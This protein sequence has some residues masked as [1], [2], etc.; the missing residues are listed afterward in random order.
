[1]PRPP[2]L[3][4]FFDLEIK[5]AELDRQAFKGVA[6]TREPDMLGDV[7]EPKG[8]QFK[9]PLPLLRQH[10]QGEP[11]GHVTKARVTDHG[12]EIEAEG[13][14]NTGL[15]YLEEAWAQIRARLVKGLSIGFAP[16]AG[17][18]EELLDKKGKWTGGL[19]FKKWTWLELS[20]VTI[21]ANPGATLQLRELAR[22]DLMAAQDREFR[23][24][25][26]EGRIPAGESPRDPDEV[27]QRAA[28]AIVRAGRTL[29]GVRK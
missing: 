28:A 18:I 1:M 7:V 9:L 27:R 23:R 17:E 10:R 19:R 22:G 11:I 14:A 12:I 21:P 13:P 20:A 5:S 29:K 15:R 24:A 4:A 3:A 6:T 16:M 8:A 26:L 2:D 25:L